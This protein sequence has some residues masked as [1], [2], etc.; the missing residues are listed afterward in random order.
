[1]E[2]DEG[3]ARAVS[4]PGASVGY[5]IW[6]PDERSL[7]VEIE[8]GGNTHLAVV[9]VSTGQM[10]QLTRDSGQVWIRSWS[11]DGTRVVAAV[12]RD[13]L[14]SLEWV[15]VRTAARGVVVPAGPPSVYYRYPDW[16][17]QGTLIAYERG[18]MH[19]NIWRLALPGAP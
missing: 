5:P 18:Q 7:A 14:W 15:D 1:M 2:V 13:R 3:R 10:R 12:R 4:S 9:D 16:S 8:D 11:P 6:S 19:G 17:P